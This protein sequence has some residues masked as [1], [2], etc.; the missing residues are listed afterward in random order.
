MVNCRLVHILGFN[1]CLPA[2]KSRFRRDRSTIYNLILLEIAIRTVFLKRNHLV[3]VFFDLVEIYKTCR[4]GIF[5][6][7]YNLDVRGNLPIF[8][9]NF[10]AARFFQVRTGGIPSS[11]YIQEERV[12]QGNFLSVTLLAIM[13][14]NALSHLAPYVQSNNHSTLFIIYTN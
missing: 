13:I 4:Y 2:F 10:L 6:D 9:R 14:N 1:N 3:S 8:I 5:R 7:L 11:I 12:P